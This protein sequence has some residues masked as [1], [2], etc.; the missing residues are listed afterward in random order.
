M[1]KLRS[2][3]HARVLFQQGDGMPAARQALFDALEV[4]SLINGAELRQTKVWPGVAA[5]FCILFATNRVPGAET[6]FRF[7]SPRI[8]RSLNGAGAMRIDAANAEIVSTGQLRET[9]EVFKILFRGTKADLGIVERIRMQGHPT[10]ASLWRKRIGAGHGKPLRGSGSGYQTVK[11]SSRV[12]RHGDGLPGA[13]AR[14]LHGLPD[15]TV[16][17]FGNI[18]VETEFLDTFSHERVH[19]P[20]ARDLFG[21][22]LLLVHKSP[23]AATGRIG[24]AISEEDVVFNE[25]FYG[26]SPSGDPEAGLLVRYLA[27]V[28]GS[29]L[30][31]WSALV[32]SG[33]F[34]FERDVIE[35]ATLDRI[36]IP[37]FEKLTTV[38]REEIGSLVAGLDAGRVS[39]TD[40]DEWVIRLYGLGERD[41]QV[42]LDTL[43]FGLPFAKNKQ[44]AQ[45]PPTSVVR[46]RFC[47]VL[48]DEL[49]PWGKRF[50][51]M[52]AV[53]QIPSLPQSPWLAVAIRNALHE[54]EVE[55]P[56]ADW[57][58][59]LKAADE[60]AASEILVR[61]T[62]NRLLVGRLAQNRYWSETQARLLAQRIA[63]S[64]VDLLGAHSEV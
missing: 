2:A 8:E 60:A 3:L 24:V 12:R 49:S 63:W 20:R 64:H 17:S 47:E 7:V 28:L 18:F 62:G 33:E 30:T 31:V 50:G 42:V 6:G 46:K 61:D 25:T 29:R 26:Y 22:P 51:S 15:L 35:K 59:L 37:D 55:V 19:D 54:P 23:P 38:Q 48:Q 16:A 27:L 56:K 45:I 10:L 34:G 9:P 5:P 53:N 13:D 32:T 40:V 43:A 21:G 58:A 52:L 11:R 1:V 41:S 14:Y 4:T 44:N 57:A 39:W 36:P